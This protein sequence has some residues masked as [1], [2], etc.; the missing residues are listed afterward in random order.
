MNFRWWTIFGIIFLPDFLGYKKWWMMHVLILMVIHHAYSQDFG[1]STRIYSDFDGYWT[2]GSG[3]IS[4]IKPNNT[5]HL[6]GFTWNGTVYSTGVDDEILNLNT[7][8]FSPQTYQAFPVRNIYEKSSGTY[9]GL[10]QMVDGVDNGVSAPPPFNVP[11]NLAGF[12]TSG[13]QGL[14]LGSGVANI[15][16]GNLIFDFS[17][18]IDETQIG[19]GIPDILVTQFAQPSTTLDEVFMADADG[20]MVGNSLS[21]NHTLVATVGQWTADFYNLDGTLDAGFTKTDRDLRLWVAD[22]SAF[23]INLANFDQVRSMRYRLNGDSDPAFA[24]YKVGVFDIVAANDDEAITNQEEPVTINVLANDLPQ[25]IIDPSTLKI[26]IGPTNGI[27]NID[28][29]T[30]SI[31][32]V[33]DPGFF[34]SDQFTYEICDSDE[35][36]CDEAVVNIEVSQIPLPVKW[37]NFTGS[38]QPQIGVSLH[39]GT[40]FEKQTDY[41][42]VQISYN[43]KHWLELA[44]VAAR[45][46]SNSDFYYDYI[47]DSG[48]EGRVYYRILQFDLNG[49]MEIS[50]VISVWAP[51][52]D[53]KEL[54]I[55]PNPVDQVLIVEGIPEYLNQVRVY[56]TSGQEETE[57]IMVTRISMNKIELSMES[58]P[59]GIYVLY[60]GKMARVFQKK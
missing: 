35:L 24:A 50:D 7:V 42:E 30:G 53:G 45:G 13:L 51:K 29:N 58:L 44:K 40:A 1:G 26:L 55:W 43:G 15:A 23:G 2:S 46:S 5:H 34:G 38:Y 17:G 25:E 52:N 3:A 41:F 10:G 22:L 19:D 36:Q 49:K 59:K 4:P 31:E 8:T 18:I 60:A 27:L 14:D 57:K 6:L 11:P 47:D 32:Y 28:W 39:W 9:I 56:N 33:P 54:R 21:I 48:G 20:N 16:A 12:L 37:L